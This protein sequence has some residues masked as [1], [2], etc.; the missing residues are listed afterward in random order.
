[1]T[2]VSAQFAAG[3]DPADGD[4]YKISNYINVGTNDRFVIT[5][6]GNVGIGTT[7]PAQTL[8]VN[9]ATA[10]L[11]GHALEFYDSN[12][13]DDAYILNYGTSAATPRA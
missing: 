5:P 1:M 11:A 6:G 2:T 13:G 3:I 12:N 9:G 8:T 4:K 10:V 7:N